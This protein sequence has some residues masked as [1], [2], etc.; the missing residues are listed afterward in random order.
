MRAIVPAGAGYVE[1]DGVKLYWEEF[2]AG[3]TT[4]VL[5]PTW[6][7]IDSRFWKAQVPYLARH[8][9]VVTFDGR[10]CGRSGRPAEAAAYSHLESAADTMAVLDATNTPDAVLVGLSCGTLWG[11]QV[12]ADRP[13]RV[14]GLILVGPQIPLAP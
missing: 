12:A 14:R 10:G 4:I 6:S 8:F 3:D 5:L 11:V 9:R 2:G 13:D 7:L 1:R